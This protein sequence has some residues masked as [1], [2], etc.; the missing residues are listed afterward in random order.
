MSNAPMRVRLSLDVE[1]ELGRRLKVAAAARD[2]T[3]TAFV[4]RLVRQALDENDTA[5]WARLSAPSF[6]RDWD[7]PEDAVYDQPR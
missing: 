4:E 5:A 7:S 6:A 3:I 1:P 2:E